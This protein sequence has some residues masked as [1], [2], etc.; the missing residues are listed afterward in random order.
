MKAD[1]GYIDIHLWGKDHW[2]TLAYIE[3]VMVECGGF[4]VGYDYRMKTNRR[5]SRVMQ[6]CPFPKRPTRSIGRGVVMKPENATKLSDGQIV[7]DHDDWCCVQ[8][9]A[10][11]GFFNLQ[12]DDI[13]P[14]VTLLFSPYGQ[15]VALELRKHKLNGGSFGD[16]NINKVRT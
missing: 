9:M 5:H 10:D 8:D 3:T 16:F 12:P 15:N 1:D 7:E 13:D 6:E 4:Q 2:S 11:Y 14:G